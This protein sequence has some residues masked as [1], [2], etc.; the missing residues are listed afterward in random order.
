MAR[1]LVA[2]DNFDRASLGADWAQLNAGNAGSITIGASTYAVG[3]G[4]AAENLVA[5][6]RWVGAGT[7]SD[8][9][10]AKA[11]VQN[12]GF[13]GNNYWVGVIVRA[14]AD[15]DNARDFYA[16]VVCDDGGS[17]RTT[18]LG[19]TVNGTWTLIA[20]TVLTWASNDTIAIEV[21]GASLRVYQN[22]AEIA[23]LASTDSSLTTGKPG[24]IC[25]EALRL[26]NWESG[27]VGASGSGGTTSVKVDRSRT[28]ARGLGRGLH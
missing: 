20:S 18:R 9:Q 7:F 10:Y 5:C 13:F 27:D 3:A 4:G 11:T 26:D 17:N 25:A 1:T 8:N 15:T 6:A 23:A 22:D 19:K 12:L 24:A 2:S 21:E 28:I 16:A 14:S